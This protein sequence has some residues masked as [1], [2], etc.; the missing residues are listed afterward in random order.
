MVL[1]QPDHGCGE[2]DNADDVAGRVVLLSQ[3]L[4][5]HQCTFDVKAAR[6]EA[7][8]AVLF[9]FTGRAV[10]YH[11]GVDDAGVYD[12]SAFESDARK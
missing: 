5:Q 9:W 3:S 11:A 10:G 2:Y 6:A 4:F 7:L 8:G 1:A 12:A